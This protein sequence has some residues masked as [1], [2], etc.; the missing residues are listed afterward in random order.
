M[1]IKPFKL[2]FI[3]LLFVSAL[4]AT[5]EIKVENSFNRDTCEVGELAHLSIK[6]KWKGAAEDIDVVNIKIPT[7]SWLKVEDTGT[8]RGVCNNDSAFYKFNVCLLFLA[9]GNYQ[10]KDVKLYYKYI[11]NEI[12]KV[13]ITSGK[14]KVN[15][16]M[17]EHPSDYFEG[18]YLFIV[19]VVILIVLIMAFLLRYKKI[20]ANLLNEKTYNKNGLI[21]NN[22]L[23]KLNNLFNKKKLNYND[24]LKELKKVT[25]SFKEDS[26]KLSGEYNESIPRKIDNLVKRIDVLNNYKFVAF[27]EFENIYHEVYHLIKNINAE[28]SIGGNEDG[29]YSEN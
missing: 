5:P 2:V 24:S 9:P 23:S 28:N 29:G 18:N 6:L 17:Y 12:E 10:L 26:L 8:S 16:R 4:S 19:L 15:S 25:L 7:V 20:K 22:Y 27:N 1:V 14:I 13:N 3:F 21:I 11:N